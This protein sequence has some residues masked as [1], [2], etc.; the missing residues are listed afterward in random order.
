MKLMEFKRESISV[1]RVAPEY[2]YFVN[3]I[4]ICF[5]LLI[6]TMATISDLSSDLVE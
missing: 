3:K 5:N 1:T 2:P 6:E 4:K